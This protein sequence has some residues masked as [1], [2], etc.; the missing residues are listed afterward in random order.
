M[1]ICVCVRALNEDETVEIGDGSGLDY[2]IYRRTNIVYFILVPTTN[3]RM[4]NPIVLAFGESFVGS[5]Q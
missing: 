1:V 4:H 3:S 5:E 2:S